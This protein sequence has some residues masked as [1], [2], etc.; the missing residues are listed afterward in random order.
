MEIL[1]GERF[2]RLTV[3]QDRGPREVE[4]RCDCGAT[5]IAVRK[6]LRNGDTRSCGCLHKEGLIAMS[7]KHG[8]TGSRL[9]RIWK[10]MR[11]RATNPNRKQASDYV[12]RGITVCDEWSDYRKFREW[13][14]CNG[15]ADNLTID[16]IDNNGPY[17]PDNCRWVTYK[18]QCR[19]K[20]NTHVFEYHGQVYRTI[21]DMCGALG[22][23]YR[24]VQARLRQGWPLDEAVTLS[25]VK[26]GPR[27]NGQKRKERE[28]CRDER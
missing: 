22:I 24:M 25:N 9:H 16:R 1:A 20:R 11:T 18:D 4:C 23:G 19:N 6:Y 26:P 21:K 5:K 28:V 12:L 27:K 2:G 17:S 8:D 10:S 13:A 14:E 15:Y 7:K 3:V